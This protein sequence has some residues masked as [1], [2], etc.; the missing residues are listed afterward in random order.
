MLCLLKRVPLILTG[1]DKIPCSSSLNVPSHSSAIAS[2]VIWYN[3]CIKVDN[4][5]LYNFKISRKDI[6]Y[7][8]DSFSN[9]MVN[10]NYGKNQKKNLTYR[11]NYSLHITK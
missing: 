3:K 8:L 6:N 4:K 2:Q 9:A 11:G 7:T 10:L 1:R 5:I